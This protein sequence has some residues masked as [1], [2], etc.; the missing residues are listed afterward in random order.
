LHRD[1]ESPGRVASEC[2]VAPIRLFRRREAWLPT[3]WGWLALMSIFAVAL[4]LG[5]RNLHEFLA[6]NQPVGASVLVVEGWLDPDGLDQAFGAFRRGGYQRIVTTGGPIEDWPSTRGY[7]SFAERAADYLESRHGVPHGLV[8]SVP[9]PPSAQ[10]RTY[11]SAVMVRTWAQRSG[12]AF[13]RLD[14]FSS[15]THARR[16]RL[17]Y[18][19]AFGPSV[20][21]GVY[22]AQS[23]DYDA[24]HWW[25]S[26]MGVRDVLEQGI[27]YMWVECCFWPSSAPFA[28]G[29][30]AAATAR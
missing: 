30:S 18:R 23:S 13:D 2:V 27:G 6:V 20:E 16:S 7:A 3:L 9:V 17:L 24:D 15:G 1:Q 22:A 14:V 11:L 12:L 8:T 25:R 21:V 29:G 19:L 28:S 10:D 5:A 4:V 26:V